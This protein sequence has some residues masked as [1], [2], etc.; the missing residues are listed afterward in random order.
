M[1]YLDNNSTTPM[2]SEVAQAIAD[3]HARLVGNPASQHE[4]GRRARQELEEAR[5]GIAKILGARLGGKHGDRLLFTSGGTESNNLAIHGIAGLEPGEIV[6]SAV[7]HPSV[8]A[9][10]D[11]SRRAKHKAIRLAVDSNGVVLLTEL[12]KLLN[13]SVKLV[14]VMVGNHETGVLQPLA[15]IAQRCTAAGIPFHTDA[16]QAVGKIPL[17]F[18]GLGIAAMTFSAHKFHGPVGIGG[19]LLRGDVNLAPLFFGGTQ[20]MGLRPGTEPVALAVGMFQALKLW[21]HDADARYQKLEMLRN[22]FEQNL[23]AAIDT[24]VIHGGSTTRLPHTSNLAFPG[25]DRQAMVMALDLEG[26]ACSTGSACTSGSSQPSAVIRSMDAPDPILEGSVRFSLGV[27]NTLAEVDEAAA[28]IIKVHRKLRDLSE[29][30][31][32]P[33]PPPQG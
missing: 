1:I 23:S 3:C 22:R 16:T 25:I 21:Q 6:V 26:I 28:R 33:A 27:L 12:E 18:R 30:G 13:A 15:E 29:H 7:E 10:A 32:S 17:D 8:L 24:V 4:L 14:S 11:A 5:N 9:A 19:L 31:K 2:L 20:Q